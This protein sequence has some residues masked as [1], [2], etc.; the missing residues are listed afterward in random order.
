MLG[1]G[2]GIIVNSHSDV[3]IS[4]GYVSIGGLCGS[5]L[6]IIN[7]YATGDINSLE[8]TSGIYAVGIYLLI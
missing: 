2:A 1:T 8:I 4:K 3:D 5:C 6:S 7:S